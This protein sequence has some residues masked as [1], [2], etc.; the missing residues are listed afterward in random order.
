MALVRVIPLKDSSETTLTSGAN[1]TAYDLATVI[2]AG[3]KIY[4]GLHV[5]MHCST[6]SFAVFVQSA[7]SSGFTAATTEFI[8]TAVTG[9]G[10]QWGTS[11]GV[12]LLGSTDRKFFRT[13]WTL[14][15]GSNQPSVRFIDWIS[16][17]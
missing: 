10:A 3:Q 9:R 11:A 13:R 14:S 17:R 7:T 5:V 4:A 1:G 8:F 6:D 16:V 15:T 2:T 12:A